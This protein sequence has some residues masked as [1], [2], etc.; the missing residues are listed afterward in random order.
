MYVYIHAYWCIGHKQLHWKL[1]AEII[2]HKFKTMTYIVWKPNQL[3]EKSQFFFQ[4]IHKQK[5]FFPL[6]PHAPS[7]TPFLLPSLPFP[8]PPLSLPPT[9]HSTGEKVTPADTWFPLIEGWGG[10]GKRGKGIKAD[11]LDDE[12]EENGEHY[13]RIYN[14]TPFP[15]SNTITTTTVTTTTITT[16]I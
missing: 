5:H 7:P 16:D 6:T 1:P 3:L 13:T 10:R 8:S 15:N 4:W 12:K 11:E 14:V 9:P 2:I